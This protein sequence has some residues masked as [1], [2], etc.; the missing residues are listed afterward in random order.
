MGSSHKTVAK[1]GVCNELKETK[2][3]NRAERKSEV[4]LS[5]N[6]QSTDPLIKAQYL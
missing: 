2:I 3:L 5:Y 4:I 1:N 6:T